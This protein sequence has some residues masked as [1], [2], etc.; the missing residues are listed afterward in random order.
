[1]QQLKKRRNFTN[2]QTE[3]ER[4]TNKKKRAIF[5]LMRIQIGDTQLAKKE[6]SRHKEEG[7]LQLEL[8]EDREEESLQVKPGK[9]Q[10]LARCLSKKRKL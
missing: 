5:L 6:E 8:E 1:M 2:S 3:R 7:I 9:C 10:N 4:A